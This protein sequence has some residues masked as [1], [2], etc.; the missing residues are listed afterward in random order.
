MVR[1]SPRVTHGMCPVPFRY[2]RR[3]GWGRRERRPR[4]RKR[5]KFSTWLDFNPSRILQAN[6]PKP[7]G[8]SSSCTSA[9]GHFPEI[10]WAYSKDNLNCFPASSWATAQRDLIQS[11]QQGCV[12]CKLVLEWVGLETG[13]VPGSGSPEPDG[14]APFP[15]PHEES[16]PCTRHQPSVPGVWASKSFELHVYW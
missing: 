11:Q 15:T 2:W 16:L 12:Y 7:R 8:L 1:E 14:H 4:K 6:P 3:K 10:H 9:W 13:K 5:E